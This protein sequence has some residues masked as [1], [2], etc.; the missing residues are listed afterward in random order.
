MSISEESYFKKY[1]VRRT[2]RMGHLVAA[3]AD[4][5]DVLISCIN[6]QNDAWY[7]FQVL[8]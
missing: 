3:T 7:L 4:N 5:I 2:W 6:D 1:T 8:I